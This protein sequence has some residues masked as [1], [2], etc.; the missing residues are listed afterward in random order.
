MNSDGT[1]RSGMTL[2]SELKVSAIN[3]RDIGP[4]EEAPAS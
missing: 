3:Q 1:K 2:G 4:D